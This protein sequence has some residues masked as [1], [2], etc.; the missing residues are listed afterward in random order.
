MT[1]VGS[2]LLLL[3]VWGYLFVLCR[4]GK[5]AFWFAPVLWACGAGLVL[6]VGALGGHFPAVCDGLL[7]GGLPG[8]VYYVACLV[9]GKV[10]LPGWTFQGVCVTAGMA[11]FA[12][13]S[14]G[15]RL[16]HYD[17]FSHW[18]LAVKY[19]LLAGELPGAETTLLPFRDYPP[20]SSLFV[21]YICRYIGHS[22]GQMLLAQNS[23]LLACFLAVFGVVREKR[24]FLLYSFLGMGLSLLS[25]LNLTVRINNLLVDFLLSLLALSSM[26]YSRREENNLRLC[27]GQI[28]L[29]GFTGIVKDTG[30]F[31]AGAAGIYAFWR[32]MRNGWRSGAAG[33]VGAFLLA[34]VLAAG[35][36]GPALA[37]QY[38]VRTG[39]AGFEGKFHFEGE[40]RPRE[41]GG[42][43]AGGRV[44]AADPGTLLAGGDRSP[45]PGVSGICPVHPAGPWGV[46]VRRGYR[47]AR[48]EASLGA[49]LG[50]SFAGSLLRGDAGDVS[51]SYAGGRSPA[52]GRV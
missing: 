8:F 29:L 5:L 10:S 20:G 30:L 19:L 4:V 24:R 36:A 21:A 25:Y 49:G 2:V 22:Q 7:A 9:R 38:H 6:F 47:E 39:L 1:K 33:R 32:L 17:N 35:T 16:T 44:A 18:A 14:L 40:D 34:V 50:S 48:M 37:W 31:F 43:P 12:F 13:L 41:E 26:A 46:R 11:A 15:L 51:L 52:S 23:L 3:S 45:G 42:D 27:A 28:L